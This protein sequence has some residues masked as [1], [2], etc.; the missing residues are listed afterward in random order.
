[1]TCGVLQ[2]SALGPVLFLLYVI[3]FA[4]RH[5]I[6]VHSY[7]DDTQLHQHAVANKCM[8]PAFQDWC[9]ASTVSTDGYRPA[10]TVSTDGYRPASTVSTDGYRPTD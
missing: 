4:R 9:P 10:S 7:T 2:G 5:Y 8:S 1:M 3:T 6:E